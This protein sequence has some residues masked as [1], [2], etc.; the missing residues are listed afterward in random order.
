[1]GTEVDKSDLRLPA[2]GD[3]SDGMKSNSIPRTVNVPSFGYWVPSLDNGADFGYWW[4]PEI[5][6]CVIRTMS[7]QDFSACRSSISRYAGQGFQAMSV[8]RFMACRSSS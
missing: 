2:I 8:H 6:G 7:V 3:I 1:M 4:L 5:G